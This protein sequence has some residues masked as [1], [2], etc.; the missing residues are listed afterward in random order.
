MLLQRLSVDVSSVGEHVLLAMG[1]SRWTFQYTHALQLSRWLYLAG[2][3]AKR[4]AVDMSRKWSALGTLHNANHPKG[5]DAGQPF[6]HGK[7]YPVNRNALPLA[8][9]GVRN[10]GTLVQMKL[11]ADT[12]TLSYEAALTIAQWLRLRAKES[13][14]RAGDIA[15]HWSEIAA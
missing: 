15:R 6:T 13:K 3:A 2:C 8:K 12:A 11:G 1:S 4:A 10:Q 14:R 7:V 9:I 5:P